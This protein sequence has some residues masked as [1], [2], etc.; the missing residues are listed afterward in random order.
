MMDPNSS[1][2]DLLIDLLLEWEERVALAADTSGSPETNLDWADFERRA[3]Q[4]P[5]DLREVFDLV[6]LHRKT[7]SEV[8]EILGVSVRTA[9]RRWLA[10]RLAL[11]KGCDGEA[12]HN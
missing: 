11:D 12:P 10:A 9:K 7:H 4:L 3:N 1:D 5:P 8:A 2:N 6:W